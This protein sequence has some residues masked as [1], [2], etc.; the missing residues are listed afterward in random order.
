M[1]N[2]IF[3]GTQR[4]LKLTHFVFVKMNSYENCS[5]FVNLV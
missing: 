5:Y 1:L 2:C 3:C 4:D